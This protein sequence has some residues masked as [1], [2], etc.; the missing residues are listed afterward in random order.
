MLKRDREREELE[1][2]AED[3][4]QTRLWLIGSEAEWKMEEPQWHTHTVKLEWE[5]AEK[6]Q[7]WETMVCV[8]G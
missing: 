2:E 8:W 5:Y 4:E 1:T 6:L 3:R 7:N